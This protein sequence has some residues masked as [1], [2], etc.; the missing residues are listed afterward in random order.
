MPTANRGAARHAGFEDVLRRVDLLDGDERH[1]ITGEHRG[2]CSVSIQ[3][4]GCVDAE[5]DPSG[6]GGEEQVSGLGEEGGDRDGCRDADQRR[7]QPIAGLVQSLSARRHRQDRDRQ[8]GRG[9]RLQLQPEACRQC[10][11]NGGPNADPEGPGAQRSV[12][13]A[14]RTRDRRGRHGIAQDCSQNASRFSIPSGSSR[15]TTA[16]EAT[17]Q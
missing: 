13:K 6:E 11:D 17:K 14:R 5:S 9:G 12:G 8:S 1:R 2:V 7:D 10:Y 4:S 15:P 3:Q 16:T